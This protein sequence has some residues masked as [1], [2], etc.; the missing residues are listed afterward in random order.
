MQRGRKDFEM[1]LM[2]R[3]LNFKLDALFA[4]FLLTSEKNFMV[5][6]AVIYYYR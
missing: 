5:D 2:N 1:E 3:S 6:N 4:F